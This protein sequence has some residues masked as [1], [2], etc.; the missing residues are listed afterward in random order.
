MYT[1]LSDNNTNDMQKYLTQ[2]EK[3][4]WFQR[5]RKSLEEAGMI[6]K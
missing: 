5:I 4:I 6:K 3:K 1:Y 2:Q